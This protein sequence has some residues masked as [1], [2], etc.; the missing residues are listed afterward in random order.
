MWRAKAFK[1]LPQVVEAYPK[2][3]FIFL[4]LTV[5]N[6]ELTQLRET[7]TGMNQAWGRLVKRAKWPADGWIRSLE[8]TRGKDGTAHPH[9]HCLL[10]VKASYFS[11][12]YYL[13]QDDWTQLWEESL[14]INYRPIVHV[15]AVRPK[16]KDTIDTL[17]AILETLKYSVKPD[18][19]I[20]ESEEPTEENK[21]WLV[22]LTTQLH[23]TRAVATGGILKEYLRE[24]EKEPEDLIHADDGEPDNCIASLIFD[25]EQRIKKYAMNDRI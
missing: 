19:L 15:Q 6:C 20:G 18:D 2:H 7:I 5:R 21:Q 10:M 13:S 24:L 4:T 17:Q 9:F 25:W 22:E 11:G 12:N 3:R 8:V 14:R 1:I 16:N 23:K